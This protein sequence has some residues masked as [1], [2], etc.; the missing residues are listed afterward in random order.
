MAFEWHG[1]LNGA[2][3]VVRKMTIGAS[4]Y[5][6][7][8]AMIDEGTATGGYIVKTPVAAAGPDTASHIVG[9]VSGIVT[10][11][12]YTASYYNGD[13]GTYSTTQA[14]LAAYD[15][16]GPAVAE[17]VLVTPTTLIKAP[18]WQTTPGTSLNCLA[19]TTAVSAGTTFVT[20]GFSAA[21]DAFTTAYCRSG[22]N[23]GQY[24]KV[25]GTGT[26]T[27]TVVIPFTYG[28]GIGDTF[29]VANIVEGYAHMDLLA[30]YLNGIDGEAALTNYY[31]VYVHELNLKEA[32]R[33]YAVFSFCSNHLMIGAGV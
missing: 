7:Q 28:V 31:K 32:G 11:P 17:V 14:T 16:P 4:L 22:A 8:L 27:Q 15:P 24:R 6:G 12:T 25:D 21:V 1:D 20:S 23:A 3:P 29:V 13:L 26:T 9:I 33:E 18:I 19:A 2:A 30:T 5:Q 10:S